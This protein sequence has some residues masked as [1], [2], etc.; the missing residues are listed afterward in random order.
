MDL[1][2]RGRTVHSVTPKT[3][4]TVVITCSINTTHLHRV[5][6]LI[7]YLPNLY[8]WVWYSRETFGRL[9]FLFNWKR[10]ERERKKTCWQTCKSKDVSWRFLWKN[11]KGK[12][13]H[14]NVPQNKS[15]QGEQW[16]PELTILVKLVL[17][18]VNLIVNLKVIVTTIWHG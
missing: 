10:R 5:K 3:D 11:K 7:N 12:I 14:L 1:G 16:F 2:I 13:S 4:R 8:L 17:K 18:I 15:N 9:L 6:T